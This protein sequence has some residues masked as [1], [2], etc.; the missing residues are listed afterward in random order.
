MK[1]FVK[2]LNLTGLILLI[3]TGVA[4]AES[5]Q[6]MNTQGGK[7]R[8]VALKN[9]NVIN[10]GLQINMKKGWKTYWYSAGNYGLPP[11]MDFS[12]SENI[13]N[14]KLRLPTP[15]MFENDKSIGYK[16]DVTFIID[17]NVVN[18]DKPTVLNVEGLIGICEEICVP[19][20]F[21]FRLP[22]ENKQS[23]QENEVIVKAIGELP[24]GKL[25]NQKIVKAEIVEGKQS[26]SV[27]AKVPKD[28][29]EIMLFANAPAEAVVGEARLVRRDVD[30]AEFA[31]EIIDGQDEINN[32]EMKYVLVADEKAIEQSMK[33][34]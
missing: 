14:V 3:V 26:V 33:L 34:K 11:Q 10:A 23:S 24:V 4:N 12:K 16:D 17:S 30:V 13:E 20:I 21:E 32:G 5:S 29:K 27:I 25:K 22:I 8:L 9:D 7:I 1:F 19:V 6:W 31:V 28:A 15:Q 18:G 2:I